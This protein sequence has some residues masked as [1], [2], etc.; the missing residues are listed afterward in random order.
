MQ[1]KWFPRYISAP[2]QILFFEMDEAALFFSLLGVAMMFET[3]IFWIFMIAL[4][5]GYHAFKTRY[6]KGFVIHVF[7]F[8]GWLK[9]DGYPNYFQQRFVE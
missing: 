8:L 7:Y 4:P 6:P 1:P 9:F 3:W 5:I 2:T